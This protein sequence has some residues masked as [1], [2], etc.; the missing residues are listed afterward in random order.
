[1][2]MTRIFFSTD[3]HGSERVFRKFLNA[4]LVYKANVIIMGG[5]L[6]GKIIT[7]IVEHPDGSFKIIFPDEEFH[8]KNSEELKKLEEK[9]KFIG[10]Y[11]FHTN[12][13]EMNELNSNK[14]KV[15]EL[16]SKMMTERLK[17]WIKIA[18]TIKDKGIKCYIMPGN[19]DRLEV[20]TVF[21]TSEFI[22]NPEGKVI[23]LDENHE[24]IST[25][26]SNISPWKAPRDIPEEELTKK[27][28]S[29]TSK[30]KN[31]NNCIFQ[32]HCPPY[33]SQLDLAPELDETL[34]PRIET[35][36]FKMVPVGSTAVHD[37]IEKY[38]PFLGLHGHIHESSG[39][40]KIGRT[41]LFNPGSEYAEG[42]LRGVILIFDEKKLHRYMFI[43]G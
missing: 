22:V 33:N 17:E 19:D 39:T 5:D 40:T 14:S 42:I 21:N 28:E 41:I 18:E 3:V 12:P 10:Y 31:M 30:V 15:N 2:T 26:Y 32:L 11:P 9:S 4:G 37:A 38:Q 23:W 24:M 6:T 27:I 20:D 36:G 16:F 1:M 35:G 7:P 43:T 25:G 29:M 8:T 13:N 34:K